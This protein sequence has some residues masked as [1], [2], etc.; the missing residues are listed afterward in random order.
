MVT[1]KL[2]V[3]GGGDGQ[4]L[5]TRCRQGFAEFLRKAG[6]N[7]KMPRI[8]ACGSRSEAYD[9][10]SGAATHGTENLSIL[11][12][13]SEDRVTA[14]SPWT[15]LL[16]RDGWSKPTWATDDHAHLMVQCM[17]S[18]LL[19]DKTNTAR[20]FGPG[21]DESKLHTTANV[22]EVSKNNLMDGLKRATKNVRGKPGY[23]KRDDSF[24]V[25]G[26]LDPN[27]V[28]RNSHSANRFLQ[29]LERLL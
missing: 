10:F 28:R 5:R 13:D 21:F 6:F 25:V 2:Y 8:V 14:V 18:W 23:S 16:T 24:A 11:L 19:A 1:A 4:A 9:R 12:V 17:E 15:H 26:F 3:E 29:T 22:E 7:E 20:Y 27:V